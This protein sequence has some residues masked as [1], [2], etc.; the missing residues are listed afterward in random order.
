MLTD[1]SLYRPFVL[2]FRRYPPRFFNFRFFFDN[3][4][5]FFKEIQVFSCRFF[6][7]YVIRNNLSAAM[8]F[9]RLPRKKFYA[10]RFH[11]RARLYYKAFF[12]RSVRQHYVATVEKYAIVPCTMASATARLKSSVKSNASSFAFDKNPHSTNAEG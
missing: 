3:Y 10:R 11:R 8:R 7:P 5:I 2:C 12:R 6:R 1:R 9:I 4:N